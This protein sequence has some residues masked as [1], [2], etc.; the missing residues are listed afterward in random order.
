MTEANTRTAWSPR[1]VRPA[2]RRIKPDLAK[3]WQG[4][5]TLSWKTNAAPKFYA[6]AMV[7]VIR[8]EHDRGALE[9]LLAWSVHFDLAAFLARPAALLLF[10]ASTDGVVQGEADS[11]REVI[12]K[13]DCPVCNIW[14]TALVIGVQWCVTGSC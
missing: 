13:R 12:T 7:I 4:R 10:A 11:T 6:C 8:R 2:S 1:M 14:S 9:D 3:E 5:P